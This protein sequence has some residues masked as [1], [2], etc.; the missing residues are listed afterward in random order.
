MGLIEQIR[1]VDVLDI[2]LVSMLIYG[3]YSLF[4]RT[5]AARVVVG[6][7]AVGVL[8]LI[9]RYL[10]LG[11]T[12]KILQAFFAV[13]IIALIVIF[14]DEVRRLF[15]RI[16]DNRWFGRV[17]NNDQAAISSNIEITHNCFWNNNYNLR[18]CPAGLE[19]LT[20]VTVKGD[21]CDTEYN[22]FM[23]PHLTVVLDT[24]YL[25]DSSACLNS[26]TDIFVSAQTGDTILVPGCGSLL[27][28][29]GLQSCHIGTTAIHWPATC[30]ADLP[31]FMARENHMTV[32]TLSG[33]TVRFQPGAGQVDLKG[34]PSGVYLVVQRYMGKTAVRKLIKLK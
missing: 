13:I 17:R 23:D 32:F 25:N 11:L 21:S 12:V 14:Q 29:R 26:G 30:P 3:V 27:P 7:A 22:L 15:E 28:H 8:Y 5:R 18:N 16:G 1:I 31:I 2:A 33:F 9:A 24:V 10:R 34:L 4:R 6:V 20:T 19:T